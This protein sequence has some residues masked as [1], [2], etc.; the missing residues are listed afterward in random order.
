MSNDMSGGAVFSIIVPVYNVSEYLRRCLDSLINQT[1]SDIEIIV[2]DDG[3]KD[4][5]PVICDEYAQSDS[6]IKV[7]HKENGGLSDARNKG[8][9][10]ATGNYVIFVD[11]DDYID[12]D[13]CDKF[14]PYIEKS[15]DIIIG[16]AYVEGG[17]C[18]LTHVVTEDVM[19]GETYL[20]RALSAE[21]A[22]M[23]VWLNVYRRE[24]LRDN[25]LNFK[26]GILHE[27][28]Q[29][30]PRCFLKANT[31]VYSGVFFY[32]YIIRPSSITTKPDK[33][34]N[35]TDLYNTCL[36]LEKIYNSLD[37]YKLKKLL[38]DSLVQKYLNM[39]QVGAL[40]QYGKT[41]VHKKF[42]FR[43]AYKCRTRLKAM[44]Y[45]LSPKLYYK[46]NERSKRRNR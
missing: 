33:R 34:K 19:T 11:S 35:A 4:E 18:N 22:S 16:D 29:F 13:A 14:L 6:R 20:L 25:G 17:K 41:Y 45:C 5:S 7:I 27:D 39:F 24:F 8:L 3:S 46:I 30:T 37:N 40:Y 26:F 36:E 12:T 23:A 2:V 15:Y 38:K 10:A 42:I 32:H 31:V 44:L 1:F 43:N 21:L 28:E 9:E